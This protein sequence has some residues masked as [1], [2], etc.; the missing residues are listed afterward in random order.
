MYIYIYIYI[1]THLYG[2]LYVTNVIMYDLEL[3]TMRPDARLRPPPRAQGPAT[4][5]PAE[6]VRS[7]LIIS[8]HKISN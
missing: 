5:V 8:I 1:Y 2:Y 3:Y 7:V 6:V 4:C